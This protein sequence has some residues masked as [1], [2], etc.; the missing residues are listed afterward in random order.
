MEAGD[1]NRCL[2]FPCA[3]LFAGLLPHFQLTF[4]RL[5]PQLRQRRMSNSGYLEMGLFAQHRA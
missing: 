3:L 2:Q 4:R 1:I 5:R